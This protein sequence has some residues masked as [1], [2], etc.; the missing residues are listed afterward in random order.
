MNT[1]ISEQNTTN[2]IEVQNVKILREGKETQPSS[3]MTPSL[4]AAGQALKPFSD[5]FLL[6]S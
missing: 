2:G 5:K 4:Q 3:S 1:I 6:A